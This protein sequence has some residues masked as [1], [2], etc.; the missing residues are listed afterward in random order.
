MNKLKVTAV[1]V[2]LSAAMWLPAM[3]EARGASWT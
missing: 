3:A 1:G 2:A